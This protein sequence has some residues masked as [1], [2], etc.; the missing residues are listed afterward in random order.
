[1]SFGVERAESRLRVLAQASHAFA[2]VVT[3]RRRLLDVIARTAAELV[4]DGCAVLLLAPDGES[5]R[6]VS[7][8]H[9]DRLLEVANRTYMAGTP[10]LVS[11]STTH[12]ASVVRTGKAVLLPI[13]DPLA[14]A[15]GAD[16]V[17]RPVIEQLN[18]SSLCVVP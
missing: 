4:G 16:A 2:S 7:S 1:M 13:L 11:S 15:A 14:L 3:D 18:I 6:V 10:I 17:L 5:L 8:A 9:R 12:T